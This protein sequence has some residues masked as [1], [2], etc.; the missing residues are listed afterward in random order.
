MK[1]LD[2]FRVAPSALSLTAHSVRASWPSSKTLTTVLAVVFALCATFGITGAAASVLDIKTLSTHADRVSGGDVLVQITLDQI[3]AVAVTLNGNDVSSA[4]HPGT[5]PNTLVG[6]VTGLN[7]GRNTLTAQDKSLVITNYSIKGPIVSGPYVQPFICQTQDFTLPDGTKLGPPTDFDCSAP[8][9]INYLYLP[10]DGSALIPLPSTSSLPANVAMTTTLTG[11][12]VPF[13]V[14]VETGTMDRGIYQNAILHDP[15]SEPTPTPFTPPKAWNKRLLA[16]HGAGCPGG[17]YIQGAA[18]GTNILT[19]TNLTRLGEGW[20]IFINTL[21]NPSTSCNATVAGEATMMGKEHFIETFGVPTYTLSTGGSGGA[22]TSEGVGNAFPGLFDGILISA[23]FPD[24]LAIPM[25]GADG[26]LLAHYFTVTNPAG[27]T[28]NQQVAVSGY[29]GQQ[30]WYD[31]ANQSGRIDPVPGRV[32]IPGYSSAVWNAAVPVAL[33]YNPVTNPGGARPTMFDWVRNIYGR[34]P[35]T[36]FGLSPFDNVG[37]QYG[38][39]ALNSGAI[40]TT[41]FLDL[42][43]SI[44]GVDQD[45][46]YVAN[47]SVGDAGAIKRTYQAGLNMDGSGG[48]RDIPVFDMGSYNDTSGYHYQWYRFAIRE[49]LRQSNGDIGNHVMWRGSSV[50]QPKAWALLNMWVTSI[51]ADQ[52]NIPEHQKVVNHRPSVLVDGCWPSTSQFVAETQ[53]LSSQ[54]NTTCNTVYPS[55][56]NPRFVAGGPIQANNYKCQLKPINPADYLPVSFTSLELNRLLSIFPSGV[57]DWSKPGVNQTGVV[58]WPSFGPSP[59]NLVF[60]VTAP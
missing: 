29:K 43:Q 56:T 14:R 41:Q 5:T 9:K 7:L 27:F 53:T 54:P 37:I 34:A 19:G 33:R 35:V 45:F 3:Q 4:F 15:T 30:A 11:L 36:G 49:R 32:D 18:E 57:C 2:R 31:A 60:D 42:N 13:V 16:Q 28:V 22:I 12:T 46:N 51:K 38:L 8:T 50:P 10:T 26:H 55:W 21:Q 23:A 24:T 17:W 25:S 58:P 47:R 20:G 59:D 40:T 48:L 44:G 6:L 52:S 1:L 39:A